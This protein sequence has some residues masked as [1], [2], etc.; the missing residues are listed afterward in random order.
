MLVALPGIYGKSTRVDPLLLDGLAESTVR[1]P[2]VGAELDEHAR[3]EHLDQREREG[4]VLDPGAL[5]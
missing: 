2:I 4:D 3:L 1:I 5:T